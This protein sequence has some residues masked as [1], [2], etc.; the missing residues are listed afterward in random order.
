MRDGNS[1]FDYQT[2]T[3]PGA[4]KQRTHGRGR[5]GR[6]RRD[7][8]GKER[9]ANTTANGGRHVERGCLSL[10]TLSKSDISIAETTEPTCLYIL[11][12]RASPRLADARL[13][14]ANVRNHRGCSISKSRP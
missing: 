3:T 11:K 6:V 13:G 12:K 9:R 14:S 4:R 5:L 1:N 7:E 8:R 2:K 10:K